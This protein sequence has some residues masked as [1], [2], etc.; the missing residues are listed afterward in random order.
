MLVLP[1][2]FGHEAFSLK[3][4]VKQNIYLVSLIIANYVYY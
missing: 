3:Q 4:S 1:T 2:V